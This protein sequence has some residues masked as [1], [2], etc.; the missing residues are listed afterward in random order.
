MLRFRNIKGLNLVPYLPK[1]PKYSLSYGQ[2]TDLLACFSI[3][4]AASPRAAGPKIVEK[5]NHTT[6]ASANHACADDGIIRC[7]HPLIID[8]D[9]QVARWLVV[10][11]ILVGGHL[12][13]NVPR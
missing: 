3:I 10:G 11:W 13:H 2:S 5:C 7:P 4:S 12:T 8:G 1:L 6:Q 9:I